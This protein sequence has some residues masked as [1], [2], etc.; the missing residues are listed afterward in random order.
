MHYKIR[1]RS[2]LAAYS[3][4]IIGS[5]ALVAALSA[6][7]AW[8]MTT[9][10][11]HNLGRIKGGNPAY[12]KTSEGSCTTINVNNLNTFDP[13]GGPLTAV[14]FSNCIAGLNN[15]TICISCVIGVNSYTLNTGIGPP[16]VF[17]KPVQ[18]VDCGLESQGTSGNCQLDN[19][20]NP[21]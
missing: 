14:A 11:D 7:D 8:T 5:A 15:T 16:G 13:P 3:L 10:P 18:L 20:G 12:R 19:N 2:R 17:P 4:M 1:S 6:G 21:Y 9:I